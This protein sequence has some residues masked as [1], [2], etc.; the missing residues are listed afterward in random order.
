MSPTQPT[1][2]FCE[3]HVRLWNTLKIQSCTETWKASWIL[4]TYRSTSMIQYAQIVLV[5]PPWLYMSIADKWKHVAPNGSS[6]CHVVPRAVYT[7]NGIIALLISTN[8]QSR[9]LFPKMALCRNIH[10]EVLPPWI[11]EWTARFFL[12]NPRCIF[13]GSHQVLF[14]RPF[15]ASSKLNSYSSARVSNLGKYPADETRE[16]SI[17]SWILPTSCKW[18]REEM[19]RFGRGVLKI[20]E[21]IWRPLK[22]VWGSNRWRDTTLNWRHR[23]SIPTNQTIT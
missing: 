6:W 15:G 5:Y 22:A 10:M 23:I 2:I 1:C 18:Q 7:H 16:G 9:D 14:A 17:I 11:N 12:Q 13:Q 8:N 20:S 21:S 3:G 4:V 19:G